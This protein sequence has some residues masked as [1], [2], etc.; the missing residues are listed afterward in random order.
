LV[1]DMKVERIIEASV[2]KLLP[3]GEH[4]HRTRRVNPGV[5]IARTKPDYLEWMLR[6]DYFDDTKVLASEA[7]KQA[8]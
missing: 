1:T 8:G 6:E 4:D 2:L 7:L 5:H 3:G